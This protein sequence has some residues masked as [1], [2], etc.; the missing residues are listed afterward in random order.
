MPAP[1]IASPPSA[2]KAAK[3]NQHAKDTAS[4][5][6]T[7]PG[8]AGEKE[9]TT[10]V[11]QLLRGLLHELRNPLS[12]I[13]TAANLVQD[14][15]KGR[16]DADEETVM[17]LE[18]IRKESLRLNHILTEFANYI[19]LPAPS[20]HPFDLAQLL[21]ECV[22]GLQ[23]EGILGPGVTIENQTPERCT[24]LADRNQTRTAL[25]NLLLNAAEAMHENGH[26]YLNCAEK[27]GMAHV[28]LADSGSGFS[29]ESE[30]RAFQP[31][32]STKLHKTGLGLSVARA[33]VEAAGGRI[34]IDTE[35]KPGKLKDVKTRICL[36]LPCG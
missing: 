5:F 2:G 15:T 17:L 12:S 24:V 23:R 3:K 31:F 4:P 36:E 30:A 19:K 21:Q 35:K 29:S 11:N 34:W 18:V 26:L 28:C 1:V 8:L 22:G 6:A 10:Q 20:P 27:N 7:R 32:Y 13:L 9:E 33:I 16:D 25:V 14:S